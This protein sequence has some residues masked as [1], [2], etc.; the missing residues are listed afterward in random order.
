MKA[1]YFIWVLTEDIKAPE[2]AL[3]Q[4]QVRKTSNEVS[5]ILF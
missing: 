5:A 1:R 4:G 2:S 3:F